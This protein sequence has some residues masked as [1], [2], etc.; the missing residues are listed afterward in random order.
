MAIIMGENKSVG[1]CHRCGKCCEMAKIRLD[2]AISIPEAEYAMRRS[3]ANSLDYNQFGYLI[4]TLGP[5]PYLSKDRTTCLIYDIR[6][7][8][9]K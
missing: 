9:C 3:G 6:P 4:V 7:A 1:N 5:C 2:P 8:L